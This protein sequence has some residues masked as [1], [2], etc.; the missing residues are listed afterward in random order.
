[1]KIGLDLD[2][3]ILDYAPCFRFAARE[4]LGLRLPPSSTKQD[5]KSLI[6]RSAGEEAWTLLQ[7]YAY[8]E[9]SLYAT[10]FPHFFE[11]V[12]FVKDRDAEL[13]VVSHKTR[14]PIT[15]PKQDLR[16]FALQNLD[17]LGVLEYLAGFPTRD[18][19]VYFCDSTEEKIQRI[20][21]MGFE[22]FVDDLFGVVSLIPG[23]VQRFHIFCTGEHE[24]HEE[25]RCV[26][27]WNSMQKV[28][29]VPN[30]TNL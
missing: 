16:G 17:R 20:R 9:F 6:K 8:G 3:T 25:V 2:N 7:G 12:K 11:F 23:E 4:I 15:G 22:V 29:K 18:N 10:L 13:R 1:M 5:Q 27:N 28:L 19:A 30:S 14:Y 21:T 26:T 24:G